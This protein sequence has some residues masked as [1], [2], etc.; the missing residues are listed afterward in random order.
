LIPQ[1]NLTT[2][3]SDTGFL[4]TSGASIA[5]SAASANVVGV[6]TTG[7]VTSNTSGGTPGGNPDTSQS[8]AS[9]NNLNATLVGA[10]TI[11]AT[12]VQS[13]TQCQCSLA[14]ASCTGGSVVT[15]LAVTVGGI[16]LAIVIDGTPNQVVTLPAGLG[17]ITINEQISAGAGDLTINALHIVLTPLGLAST[18]LVIASSHSDI[19]CSLSPTAA[20]AAISG[21]VLNSA[22][23]PVLKARV[24][25]QDQTGA[26]W[27]AVTNAFGHYTIEDLPSGETYFIDV[28]HKRYAFAP[29]TISLKDN[30]VDVDFT[31]QP[32]L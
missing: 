20:G 13:N 9:V 32:E 17:S 23:Q 3:V 10:V 19:A 22:G 11:G 31:A 6:L 2:L 15:S 16:P 27:T 1:S 21:R 12:L 8:N 7:V 25:V 24:E 5:T 30:I 29:R 28:T 26:V 4:P 18:N 14:V